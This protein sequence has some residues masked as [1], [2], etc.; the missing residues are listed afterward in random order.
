MSTD[1]LI[2]IPRLA[3]APW[4]PE[5][6]ILLV[7]HGS[8]AYGTS[9]P[10]SDLDAKGVAVPPP[11]YFHGFSR[12]FE[13]V[14]TRA[15]VDLVIYDI[16]KFMALAAECNPNIIE[17][18]WVDPEDL[19]VVTEAGRRL[20]AHRRDFLSARARHTFSGYAMS[21]L[22]R[23]HT[24]RR[25][26]LNP[27]QEE[28]RRADFGLPEAMSLTREQYGAAEARIEEML[29]SWEVDWSRFD[30]VARLELREQLARSLAEQE[31]ASDA[32]FAAAAR[33]VGY[34]ENFIELITREKRYRQAR[35]EWQQYQTW[36]RERNPARAKL[37]AE[38]GYDAKH[39]AHLVRLLR[40][41]REILE[42]GEVRVRRP[43][44]AELLAIRQGA[45]SFDELIAW[46]EA[47]QAE[48]DRLYRTTT[49]VPREP[50]LEALD[51]LC[52]ELVASML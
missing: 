50:D 38:Y 27:P 8:H 42:T 30:R 46:A 15:P 13:Q 11:R 6:T 23:I 49:A 45:W 18:L 12:R 21:Q 25:W 4:L 14:E 47:Q 28:P 26:L 52:V 20:L 2:Q 9:T 40:M 19:L 7:R 48:L 29:E 22:K 17:V 51:A 41:C 5:R 44:A 35:K 24:H 33:H 43:D 39:A 37:E 10:S 32:R 1:D 16:R 36:Q 3:D 31:A 34:D